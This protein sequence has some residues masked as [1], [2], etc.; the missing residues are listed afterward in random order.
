[1]AKIFPKFEKNFNGSYGEKQVFDAFEKLPDDWYVFHSVKWAEKRNNNNITW[2]EAD[3]LLLN[4]RFG[5][6]VL[7]VKSGIIT[8]KDGIFRQK[9]INEQ[10]NGR[11]ITPFEQADR[12]KYKILSELK[13]RNLGDCCFIDKAVWFPSIDD[14]FSNVILPMYYKKELILNSKSLSN[15]LESIE[16]VF[17]YYN[18]SNFTALSDDDMKTIIEALIPCFDLVPTPGALKKELDYQFSQLTNEQ[19]KI[20]DFIEEEDS[21]AVCGAAGTG[22]TFVAVERANRLGASEKKV[23]YLCFNRKLIDYLED[24]R[25]EQNI[26]FY[27]IFQFLQRNGFLRDNYVADVSKF[28]Q[29]SFKDDEYDYLIIDEAQDLNN[30][31]LKVIINKAKEEGIGV[32]LFYDK[33]QLIINNKLPNIISDFDCK[34][35]LKF[36]CRNTIKIMETA[37]NSIGISP[38]P[39][40]LSMEGE[41]PTLHYSDAKNN[42][43]REIE[44]TINRDL[45]NGYTADDITILTMQTESSSVLNDVQSLA[46]HKILDSRKED[47]IMFTTVRKFKGLESP[48]I[49][50]VDYYPTMQDDENYSMLFYVASSRARQVLD[51]FSEVDS[52]VI[53]KLGEEVGGL[54]S[55][56][57]N[58]SGHLKMAVKEI[59]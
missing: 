49:I 37:N 21:I 52:S 31:V 22:K 10:G 50:I 4:Q 5:M 32:T 38:N 29:Y 20:L 25:R 11:V 12:S 48:C 8:C 46:G 47:A 2:G 27:T 54:F 30:D 17:N 53:K 19:K 34:L 14:D 56:V 15:P 23:L 24:N 41:I 36:N 33:N 9:R 57:L 6:L 45:Q 42:I 7:E 1:M 13:K 16:E 59:K 39:S 28:S 44:K 18:A 35:S 51:V 40:H 55:P 43:V 3:F 26:D 58:L